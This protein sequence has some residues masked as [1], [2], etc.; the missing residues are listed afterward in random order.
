MGRRPRWA[1]KI[2]PGYSRDGDTLFCHKRSCLPPEF[3]EFCLAALRADPKR[4]PVVKARQRQITGGIGIPILIPQP[5]LEGLPGCQPNE[6]LHILEGADMDIE[7]S[8]KNLLNTVQT[9]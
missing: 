5:N 1:Q 2:R 7:I 3:R 4:V 9:G 8:H 6:I